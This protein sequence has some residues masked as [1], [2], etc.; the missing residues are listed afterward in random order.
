V[1]AIRP[2]S[3]TVLGWDSAGLVLTLQEPAAVILAVIPPRTTGLVCA[4]PWYVA[5][6]GGEMC[7]LRWPDIDL[8]RGEVLIAGNVVRVPKQALATRTPRR[9][10]STGWRLAPA[11]SSCCAPAGSPAKDA[12]AFGT[13][14]AASRLPT[15]PANASAPASTAAARTGAP[16][17]RNGPASARGPQRPGAGQRYHRRQDQHNGHREQRQPPPHSANGQRPSATSGDDLARIRCIIAA[18]VRKAAA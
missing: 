17:A 7:G 10:P 16:S 18:L 1:A 4:W 14:L 12:L 15:A 13:T 5:P 3:V 8:E 2:E 6:D 9:T 11:R